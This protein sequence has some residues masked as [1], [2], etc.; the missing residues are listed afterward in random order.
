MEEYSM[1]AEDLM[2]GGAALSIFAGTSI[3]IIAV[4]AFIFLFYVALFIVTRIPFYKMAKK[5]GMSKAW[6]MWIPLADMYVLVNLS[7]R[8]YN[9]F[10]WIRTYNRTKVFWFYLIS[11]PVACAIVI[12]LIVVPTFFSA[13]FYLIP[14]LGTILGSSIIIICTFVAYGLA[15]IYLVLVSILGWRVNYDI[16][17][18]YGMQQHAMWA[19]IVNCFF[20]LLMT[21]FGYIIMNK[22]PDYSI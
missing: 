2:A 18:T 5:A 16:L 14:F 1:A 17:M 22:E 13:F 8:E 7:K 6:L 9:L 11:C 21:V 4:Y 12:G 15:G 10:N 20:P 19:S 3:F